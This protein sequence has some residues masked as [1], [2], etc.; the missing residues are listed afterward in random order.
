MNQFFDDNSQFLKK[1]EGCALYDLVSEIKT[2]VA[3]KNSSR[4]VMKE[5][6]ATLQRTGKVGVHAILKEILATPDVFFEISSI[7]YLH[8]NG[9]YKIP[10]FSSGLFTI[11]LHI[12]LAGVQSKE[13]LHDHRWNLASVVLDGMLESEI[14]EENYS[15]RAKK[16]DEYLYIDKHT[17]PILQ[18]ASRVSMKKVLTYKAGECYTLDANVLHRIISRGNCLTA[19]LICHSAY[20]KDSARNIITN[21]AVPDVK[22]KYLLPAEFEKLVY[23]YL[24]KSQN[25]K[26]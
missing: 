13:T 18:G 12:W 23:D 11:R 6:A 5:I 3:K 7:S 14:W 19:T 22:P 1:I 17:T 25:V 2:C 26:V 21:D 9:F 8:K 4:K 20:F 10:L 16:Y 15:P 24:E